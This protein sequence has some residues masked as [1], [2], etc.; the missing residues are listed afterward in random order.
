MEIHKTVFPFKCSTN[1]C[2]AEYDI[3]AFS[4]VALFWGFIFVSS[5]LNHI[6]G[7]NCPKCGKTTVKKLSTVLTDFSFDLLEQ[8]ATKISSYG[9]AIPPNF[10]F[11]V[12]F[13]PRIIHHHGLANYSELLEVKDELFY[14]VP[15]GIYLLVTYPA[16]YFGNG[17]PASDDTIITRLL[18]IENSTGLRAF[19]R[20][21]GDRNPYYKLEKLLKYL[22]FN[23]TL[24]EIQIAEIDETLAEVIKPNPNENDAKNKDT[25]QPNFTCYDH[26]VKN[27]INM[28]EYSELN[29]T[30]NSFKAIHLP[31]LLELLNKYVTDRN[32]LLFEINFRDD[33]FNK[34]AREIYRK[35]HTENNGY[36]IGYLEEFEMNDSYGKNSDKETNGVQIEKIQIVENVIDAEKQNSELEKM[37]QKH[38]FIPE[39]YK[40]YLFRDGSRW[41][42][43]FDDEKCSLINYIGLE[44]LSEIGRAHV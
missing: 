16:E 4:E 38:N 3:Q 22:K 15:F 1:G 40:N 27:D 34:Y 5:G 2:G 37:R 8:Y 19:P 28:E 24:N 30:Y 39:N 14:R 13:S 23:G 25:K 20:I 12:P 9:F 33:F 26:M 32:G 29:P 36:V 42:I 35:Q 6:V 11:W 43:K 18:E 7:L 44:Y 41:L 10:R 31:V 17:I 21:I